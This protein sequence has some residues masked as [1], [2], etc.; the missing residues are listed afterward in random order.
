M[1]LSPDKKKIAMVGFFSINSVKAVPDIDIHF[2]DI[3]FDN[4]LSICHSAN[5][6]NSLCYFMKWRND[7]ILDMTLMS[8]YDKKMGKYQVE[9][10]QAE[11]TKS[12]NVY[13]WPKNPQIEV[14]AEYN[15]CEKRVV[16]A[17]PT[18]LTCTV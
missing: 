6:T 15:Y 9:M 1:L 11:K 2:Y 16:R 4:G 10:S 12:T 3:K 18:L 7:N 13:G 14:D 5:M 8:E 17:S